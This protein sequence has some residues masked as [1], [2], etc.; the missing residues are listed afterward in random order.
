MLPI[1]NQK[2]KIENHFVELHTHSTASDGT[3]SPT[4]LI[5]AVT[6]IGVKKA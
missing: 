3:F 5:L 6:N 4:D 1:E 2:S